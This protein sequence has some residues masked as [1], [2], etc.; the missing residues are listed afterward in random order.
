MDDR[1]R[2]TQKIMEN[3]TAFDLNQAIQRWRENLANSP[4]FRSENLNEL[5][6]HLRDSI[7]TLETG[8]CTPRKLS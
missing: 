4:A 7:S 8:A 5:E 2:N 3:Q 1:S 6:S